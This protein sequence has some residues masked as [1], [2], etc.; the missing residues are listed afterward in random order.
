MLIVGVIILIYSSSIAEFSYLNFLLIDLLS[1]VPLIIYAGYRIVKTP[2][3][4]NLFWIL[5]FCGI[6]GVVG[7]DLIAATAH[8]VPNINWKTETIE[9][10]SI[11]QIVISL[12]WVIIGFRREK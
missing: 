12:I 9:C 7:C 10:A 8:F 2:N 3:T 4:P 11:C 5:L 1:P 6:G